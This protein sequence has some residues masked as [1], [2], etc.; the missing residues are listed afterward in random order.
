MRWLRRREDDSVLFLCSAP[1]TSSRRLEWQGPVN[2]FEDMGPFAAVL[3]SWEDRFGSVVVG[4]GFDTLTLAVRRPPNTSEHALAIA[5]E[6][7]AFCMDNVSQGAGSITAY[8]HE[9]KS[10]K[11][12]SFWWD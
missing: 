4:I 11:V 3:R 8:S 1:R 10:Q 12:W 5:G 9:L 2:Y 6:H 7:Y